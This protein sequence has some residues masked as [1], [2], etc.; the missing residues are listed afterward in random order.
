MIADSVS[1]S[2]EIAV[3]LP[4]WCETITAGMD[5]EGL[6]AAMRAAD[7]QAR[8]DFA[9]ELDAPASGVDPRFPV[10]GLGARFADAGASDERR[11]AVLDPGLAPGTA[12]R[13][14]RDPDAA[15]RA[16]AARHPRLPVGRLLALLD[17]QELGGHAAAN[18]ALP[19]TVMC[20]LLA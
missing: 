20:G 19:E 3:R 1:E 2:L 17:D 14:T 12:D 13:L 10:T 5:E 16:G 18:P 15:V 8:E 4:W 9:P 6:R 11:L 7:D